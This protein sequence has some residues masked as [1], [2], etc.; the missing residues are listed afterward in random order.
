MAY[1]GLKYPV[2]APLLSETDG[3]MPT[4]G[5]GAVIG[6]AI[7][8]EISWEEDDIKLYADDALA[9]R[10][11]KVKEGAITI[12]VDDIP[13]TVYKGLL[14]MKDGDNEGELDDIGTPAPYVGVGYYKTKIKGGVKSFV[15]FWYFKTQFGLP[16]DNAETGGEST[17]FSTPEISGSVF[18]VRPRADM[19]T[20]FRRQKE[21]TGDN[22][23]ADA[24]AW[25]KGLAHIA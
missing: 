4:Y 13:G 22:A 7:K 21:F 16:S 23:E 9:E 20:T 18:S 1:T 11:N 17:T 25:L 6:K 2:Y 8:A 19:S 10:D 15:A 3:A 24:V 14:G 5:T 12:G